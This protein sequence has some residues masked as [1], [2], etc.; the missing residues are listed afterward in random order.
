[1]KNVTFAN[2]NLDT[3]GRYLVAASNGYYETDSDFKPLKLTAREMNTFVR[4]A[5]K[6]QRKQGLQNFRSAV[7]IKLWDRGGVKVWNYS[8]QVI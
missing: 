4:T 7:V 8:H 1:M 2:L 3:K 6:R 5:I